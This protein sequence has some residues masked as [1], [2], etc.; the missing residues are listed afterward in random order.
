MNNGIF[1]KS[2]FGAVLIAASFALCTQ[3]IAAPPATK[4]A[5]TTHSQAQMKITYL[6]FSGRP[7][8]SFTLA[9]GKDFDMVTRQIGDA[10][11]TGTRVV[12]KEAPAPVLGYNGILIEYPDAAGK[13]TRFVL[14]SNSLRNE[15]SNTAYAT[16][17]SV[18]AMQLEES[19]LTLGRNRGVLDAGMVGTIRS[20]QR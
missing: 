10:A 20:S 3:S 16:T 4:G 7:N 12:A 6:V 8:P 13:L 14:K 2:T 15:S 17:R 9:R 18:S 19:L 1:A 5:Q 11:R